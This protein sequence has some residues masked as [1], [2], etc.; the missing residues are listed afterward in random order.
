MSFVVVVCIAYLRRSVSIVFWLALLLIFAIPHCFDVWINEAVGTPHWHVLN[1]ASIFV[2]LFN[3]GSIGVLL[4]L[5][6]SGTG[7]VAR[8]RLIHLDARAVLLEYFCLAM[9]YSG[10]VIWTIGLVK[11]SGGLFDSTWSDTLVIN[12]TLQ[13]FGNY[14]MY[15]GA[16]GLSLAYFSN[17]RLHLILFLIGVAYAIV[18]VRSRTLLIPACMPFILKYLYEGGGVLKKMKFLAISVFAGFLIFFAQQFRYIGALTSVRDVS[19][20]DL[21][22]GAVLK[23]AAG[24]GEFGL[25]Y[26]FYEFIENGRTHPGFGEGRTY[27]RLAL[28]WCPTT[29]LD[30]VGLAHIKPRDFAMDMYDNYEPIADTEGGTMHPTIYGDMYANF[31]EF[32]ILG[33]PSLVLFMYLLERLFAKISPAVECAMLTSLGLAYMLFARGAVYNGYFIWLGSGVL[34]SIGWILGSMFRRSDGSPG[35]C[36]LK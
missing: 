2:L 34:V 16:G 22:E 25:R 10:L 36:L 23:I 8:F 14:F 12:S 26:A 27:K 24:Q 28:F 35:M 30:S 19:V 33:G 3:V 21:M 15:A 31:F 4:K 18:V 7:F 11:T 20:S 17:H 13:E 6:S 32:G 29:L 1:R 9:L 5:P